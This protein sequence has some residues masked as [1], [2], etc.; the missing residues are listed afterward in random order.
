MLILLTIGSI[1]IISALVWLLDR[2]SPVKIC[3]ICAGV[4]LTWMWLLAAY[5]AGYSIDPLLPAILMGGTVVGIAYRLEYRLRQGR[6]YFAW[7]TLFIPTG[8][9]A[10]YS[11]VRANWFATAIL[12]LVIGII[13]AIFVSG[14]K[15]M[16][17]VD[18]NAI[19]ELEEKLKECC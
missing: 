19:K 9:W 13:L 4:S 17:K 1:G 10:V 6:Y 16:V 5:F 11:I 15:Q 12:F 14:K 3:P 7:K 18:E 2:F 8:F